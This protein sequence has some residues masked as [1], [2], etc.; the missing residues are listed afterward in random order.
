MEFYIYILPWK[1]MDVCPGP[2]ILHL[3][4]RVLTFLIVK[5]IVSFLLVLNIIHNPIFKCYVK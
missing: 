5:I 4:I 2:Q 1:D 3:K